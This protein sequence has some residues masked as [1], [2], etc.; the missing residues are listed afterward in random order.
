MIELTDEMRRLRNPAAQSEPAAGCRHGQ[1][2]IE[3]LEFVHCIN[4]GQFPPQAPTET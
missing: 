4:S 3:D 2:L 1:I